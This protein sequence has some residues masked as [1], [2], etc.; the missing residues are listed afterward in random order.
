[1]YSVGSVCSGIEAASVAWRPFG[2]KF[3]WFSEIADFPSRVLKEKYPNTPNIGDMNGIPK[4]IRNQEITAPDIICGG[5]PCQAFSLA[6]WK[7]GL[8]DLRGNLTMNFI[9]MGLKVI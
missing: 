6:G 5:T 3:E 7:N 9:D 1:M 8:N 4:L 2:F